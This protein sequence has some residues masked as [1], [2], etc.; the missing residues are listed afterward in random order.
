MTHQECLREIERLHK[1]IDLFGVSSDLLFSLASR[2]TMA[3]KFEDDGIEGLFEK[4]LLTTPR[5]QSSSSSVDEG[6]RSMVIPSMVSSYPVM[7][8]LFSDGQNWHDL[9]PFNTLK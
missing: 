2:F 7:D 6:D 9:F 4:S 5:E 8:L 3:R 1:R